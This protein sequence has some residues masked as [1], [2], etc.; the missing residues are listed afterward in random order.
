MYLLS[1]IEVRLAPSAEKILGTLSSLRFCWPQLVSVLGELRL[2]RVS[3]HRK[4]IHYCFGHYAV[5]HHFI[6]Q[7]SIF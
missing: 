7:V 4:I 5:H 2:L 3:I 1:I 6:I